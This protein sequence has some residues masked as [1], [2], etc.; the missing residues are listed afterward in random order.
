MDLVLLLLSTL[1]HGLL[2][3]ETGSGII[4]YVFSY[5]GQSKITEPYLITF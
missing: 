4:R 2:G 3:A 1:D 5:E